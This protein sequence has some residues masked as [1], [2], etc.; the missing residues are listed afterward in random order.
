M[1]TYLASLLVTPTRQ[2]HLRLIQTN[3][4]TSAKA[5]YAEL[6]KDS[7]DANWSKLAK[8][9]SLDVNG[10]NVGGDQ[11][12]VPPGTGDYLIGK[13][14]YASGRNVNDMTVIAPDA[15]GTYD[16]VQVLGFD[17]SRV[18]AATTLSAAK[19]NALSHW[20]GG[21]RADLNNHVTSPD[22]NMLT[23]TRN[24]PVTPDLNAT[25]PNENPTP[26]TTGGP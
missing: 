7:S 14:A 13:W 12:W 1:Q 26:P 15:N 11:G 4:K 19:S 10:K 25:L 21:E 22:Q 16:V 18:V 6:L 23:D 17:P 3:D 9:K 20:L 5:I 2:V 24:I 8:Q